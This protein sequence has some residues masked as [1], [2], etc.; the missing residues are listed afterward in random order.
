MVRL[1]FLL[2][3]AVVLIWFLGELWRARKRMQAEER[4]KKAQSKK[5]I[6]RLKLEAD[7]IEAEVDKNTKE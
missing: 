1:I 7:A 6:A 3:M 4:V 5:E 2:I